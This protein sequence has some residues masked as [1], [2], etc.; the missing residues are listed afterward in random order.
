M[1]S[2]KDSKFYFLFN[3]YNYFVFE[4]SATRC[5]ECVNLSAVSA[6]Y[7]VMKL[8]TSWYFLN[9]LLLKRGNI[10]MPECER[11]IHFTVSWIGLHYTVNV[12]CVN[13]LLF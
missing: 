11:R 10:N 1:R 3:L 6:G 2:F 7:N 5:C 13:G 12:P 8:D 9:F 4:T